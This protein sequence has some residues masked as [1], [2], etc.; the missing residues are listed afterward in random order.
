MARV[1]AQSFLKE[2]HQLRIFNAYKTFTD[3]PGFATVATLDEVTAQEFSLSIPLYVRRKVNLGDQAEVKSL[4]QVWS[5]W[6]ESGQDFW[7]EMDTLVE[8]L[9]GLKE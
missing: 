7:Q 6:E 3:D 8:M 5:V 1:Q 9:D 4:K 2:E